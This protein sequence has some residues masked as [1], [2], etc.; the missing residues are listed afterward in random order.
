MGSKGSMEH[1]L[2][3]LHFTHNAKLLKQEQMPKNIIK[4]GKPLQGKNCPDHS[5]PTIL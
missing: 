3:R 5:L 1:L 4:Q 2:L